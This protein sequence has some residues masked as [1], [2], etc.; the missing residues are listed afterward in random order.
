MDGRKFEIRSKKSYFS[1]VRKVVENGKNGQNLTPS[2]GREKHQN[3]TKNLDFSCAR[4]QPKFHQKSGQKSHK[5]NLMENGKKSH[6]HGTVCRKF[7]EKRQKQAKNR[8]KKGQI[9]KKK[10]TLPKTQAKTP[11]TATFLGKIF[12]PILKFGVFSPTTPK[13][14]KMVSSK[15]RV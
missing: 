11:K 15:S 5:Q 12:P 8:V 10:V 3:L 13:N 9:Y 14:R 2:R 6:K 4:K 1:R 7:R